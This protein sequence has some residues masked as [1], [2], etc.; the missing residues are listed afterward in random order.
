MKKLPYWLKTGLFLA[1]AS[2]LI[3]VWEGFSV[4]SSGPLQL[5]RLF[6]VPPEFISIYIYIAIAIIFDPIYV[7]TTPIM[8][9]VTPVFW[10]FMG[11]LISWI[12]RKIK[13]RKK[14]T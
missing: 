6:L 13:L 2:S 3:F 10:F 12:V 9:V 7:L 1:I 14:K 4:T 8:F 5:F 11:A